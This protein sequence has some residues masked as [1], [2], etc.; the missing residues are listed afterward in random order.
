MS[1]AAS[2]S[3]PSLSAFSIASQ[4]EQRRE[5]SRC[6]RVD[7][8]DA[9]ALSL[10][11]FLTCYCFPNRPVLLLNACN[12]WRARAE[13][14]V[15]AAGACRVPN[16]PA[17]AA[18]FGSD[19]VCVA[20]CADQHLSDQR[21]VETTVRQYINAWQRGEYAAPSSIAY[22]KDWHL[23]KL[24]PEPEERAFYTAPLAFRDDWV[25]A[26]WPAVDEHG[27]DFRFVYLGPAGSWTPLHRDVF[28][29]Y[30]WSAN[31]CGAKRWYL[32]PPAFSHLLVNRY[33]AS[34]L[35]SSL[36]YCTLV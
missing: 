11:Q 10:Q 29:S 12:E 28:R 3:S 5:A 9:S 18:A 27:D 24:H 8:V 19:T 17:L 15:D 6:E 7:T 20:Q 16:L 23:F 25:Q 4:L 14:T 22:L 36:D 21:R 33:T 2:A 1:D 13:W 34:T 35:L 26:H 32:F 30:S 31:V